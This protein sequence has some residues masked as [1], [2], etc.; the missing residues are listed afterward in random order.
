VSGGVRDDWARVRARFEEL[1][2]LPAADRARRLEELELE[3][4]VLRDAYLRV[5]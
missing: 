3:S 2:E 1:A 4:R 5:H